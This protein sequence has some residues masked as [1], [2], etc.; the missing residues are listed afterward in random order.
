VLAASGPPTTTHAGRGATIPV[1]D[2]SKRVG[3]VKS[4]PCPLGA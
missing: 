1:N 3:A 4:A 2:L